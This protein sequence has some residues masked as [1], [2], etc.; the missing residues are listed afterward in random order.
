MLIDKLFTK[1]D[2][3]GEKGVNYLSE[4]FVFLLSWLITS[5]FVYLAH[6]IFPDSVVL[7]NYKFGLIDAIIYSGFWI[8]FL[9]WAIK[10]LVVVRGLHPESRFG[11]LVF[12]IL[13]GSA[14]VWAVARFA[15]F[16][17]LGIVNYRW[18]LLLGLFIGFSV[19]RVKTFIKPAR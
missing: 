4:H 5:F 13:I 9:N 2:T 19:A 16:T 10:D 7:G 1:Y 17:G 18:A 11:S 14:A 3:Q 6:I 8:S 12:Y 15:P